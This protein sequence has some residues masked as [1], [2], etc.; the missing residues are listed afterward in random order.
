MAASS[1]VMEYQSSI[2][3]IALLVNLIGSIVLLLLIR[4]N[5]RVP[6]IVK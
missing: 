6:A 5:M 3:A 2:L 1:F 4:R